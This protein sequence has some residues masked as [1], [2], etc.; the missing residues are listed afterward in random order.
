MN[1]TM[2]TIKYLLFAIPV[3]ALIASC[4]KHEIEYADSVSVGDNAM[5]QV[6][7]IAPVASN[8]SNG[9]DSIYIDDKLIAG[10]NGSQLLSSGK[11]LP[12]GLS[13]YTSKFFVAS[14]GS[15]NMKLW[16]KGNVVYDRDITLA[17]GRQKVFVYNLNEDPI[18]ID[19]LYP[20]TVTSGQPTTDTFDSDSLATIRFF[21]FVWQNSTTPYPGKLQYQWSNNSDGK[22]IIGDWHNAG[23]PVGFGE[24]TEHCPVIIHKT[25]FNSSGYQTIR[26]R[27]LNEAGDVVK[28]TTDYW[29]FYIGRRYN[30]FLRGCLTG[31]PSAAYTQSNSHGA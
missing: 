1:N 7:Y 3:A 19:E 30:H 16:K 15:H 28:G 5:F 27:C 11:P 12:E 13:N 20:Y 22:Y 17:T 14:K 2:K 18:I 9:L 4:D 8:T 26:F 23:E 10:A 29:T 24:A 6:S 31:S 25:V 21:N